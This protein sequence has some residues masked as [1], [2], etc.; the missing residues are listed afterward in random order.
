MAL[1]Q[2]GGPT[3]GFFVEDGPDTVLSRLVRMAFLSHRSNSEVLTD[4]KP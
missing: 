4:G 1:Q 2:I 3:V